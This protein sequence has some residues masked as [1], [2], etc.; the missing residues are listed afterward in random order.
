MFITPKIIDPHTGDLYLLY[1]FFLILYIGIFLVA[2]YYGGKHGQEKGYS[3][4]LCFA[5]CLLGQ[6]V[7]IIV[8][9]LLP[10]QL[11]QSA[12]DSH[13]NT[14]MNKLLK[15]IES[16][17]RHLAEYNSSPEALA[18]ESQSL[19]D[20]GDEP[21]NSAVSFHSRTEENIACPCCGKRQRGNRDAC[22]S[23]G[24]LFQYENEI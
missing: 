9:L 3:F 20:I 6:F 17:E 10:N 22:Y 14:E 1:W 4:G 16:L 15:R 2:S 19:S 5:L 13:K 7:G 23:C 11:Q 21:V 24:T 18:I 8:L 12:S